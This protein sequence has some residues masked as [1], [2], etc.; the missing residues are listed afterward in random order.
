MKWRK[1]KKKENEKPETDRWTDKEGMEGGRM[2]REEMEGSCC[3]VGVD[4]V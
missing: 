4:A 1:K 3:P 2:V